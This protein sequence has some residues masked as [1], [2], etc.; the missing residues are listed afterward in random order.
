MKSIAKGI[1]TLF[2]ALVPCLTAQ[3][4]EPFPCRFDSYFAGE[5]ESADITA[6]GYR[7]ELLAGG[8]SM[9]YTVPKNAPEY[10]ETMQFAKKA[11]NAATPP[12]GAFLLNNNAI[13]GFTP[14]YRDDVVVKS[15]KRDG[16]RYIISVCTDETSDCYT[17]RISAENPLFGSAESAISKM[18]SAPTGVEFNSAYE[19]MG[20]YS[21]EGS[22]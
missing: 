2:L 17:L 22:L 16:D 6:E 10:D 12:E 4:A 21:L 9:E 20:T 3:A 15:H 5:L 18:S 7:I 8:D 14:F 11:Q 13:C 19:V 1:L